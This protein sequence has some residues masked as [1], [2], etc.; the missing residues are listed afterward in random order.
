[1]VFC[2][3][4]SILRVTMKGITG[5]EI[6]VPVIMSVLSIVFFP[7]CVKQQGKETI[8]EYS[9]GESVQ[10]ERQSDSVTFLST[11]LNPV[12]EADAFR[13][14]ILSGFPGIVDFRPNDTDYLIGHIASNLDK[15]S[16]KQILLGALHGDL[17][18]LWSKDALAPIP[19]ELLSHNQS[20]YRKE[21]LEQ[22]TFGT[23]TQYYLPWMQAS[24]VFVANTKALPF[25]PEGST[26]DDL[27][28][29]DLLAWV[30]NIHE[31]T[32]MRALG[33][34][35][36][37]RGLMHRFFQGYLYPSFTGRSISRFQSREAV[38]MWDFMKDLWVY[39]N[40][41]SL[42][43]SSMDKPLSLGEVWIAWDHTVR[44]SSVLS[45]QG[46][47]FVSFPAPSGPKGRGYMTIL[48]GLALPSGQT[49]NDSAVALIR[50]LSKP[51]I[52]SKLLSETGFFPV[53]ATENAGSILPGYQELLSTINKQS[54]A[55]DSI[56]TL[57]PI[58]LGSSSADYNSVFMLTFSDIVLRK[59]TI[60]NVLTTYANEIRM[61]MEKEGA[62]AS[63]PDKPNER[64]DYLD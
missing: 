26:L 54:N 11:Q 48:S 12:S 38:G 40:P 33:F 58:G 28:Y 17:Y 59:Q 9:A 3:R 29:Q 10:M 46:D 1:M 63:P 56:Q 15:D 60:Q 18:T 64:P 25:L 24:F 6:I 51:D 19:E 37:Q 42:T 50:Y 13:T 14:A 27:T 41:G 5:K 35:A 45:G 4:C 44:V 7:A 21:L 57:L 31:K 30:E 39:T 62:P 43:Y 16:N 8:K 61:I 53:V 22:G 36:G 47:S 23:G 2:P 34:P 52:Q 49:R 32:G 20:L 55:Q